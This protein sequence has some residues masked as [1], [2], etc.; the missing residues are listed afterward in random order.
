MCS[1][2]PAWWASDSNTC[3]VSEPEYWPPMTTVIC[4]SGS[5]VCTKYGRPETSTVHVA[6]ASSSGT[7]AVPYR[8]MPDLSPRASRRASPM[9][10]AVSSTVWWASMCRS[11]SVLTVRSISECRARAVSMW[12]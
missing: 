9:T 6:M 4:R 12:S 2:R 11:P 1:V 7:V 5:P 10:I 3:D 8:R